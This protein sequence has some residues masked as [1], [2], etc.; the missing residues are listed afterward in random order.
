MTK[1]KAISW[2]QIWAR[3]YSPFLG[4]SYLVTFTRK[5]PKFSICRNRRFVPEGGLYGYYFDHDELQHLIVTFENYLLKQNI[6]QKTITNYL[7]DVQELLRI[8]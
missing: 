6:D 3:K 7:D 4:S 2:Q 1:S 8:N 5:D